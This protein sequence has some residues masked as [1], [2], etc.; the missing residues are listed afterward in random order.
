MAR[1]LRGAQWPPG[2][3]AF[4]YAGGAPTAT[5]SDLTVRR[6]IP[7]GSSWGPYVRT[8]APRYVPPRDPPTG[9][10]SSVLRSGLRVFDEPTGLRPVGESLRTYAPS[11]LAPPRMCPSDTCSSVLARRV[12]RTRRT[13]GG[14]TGQRPVGVYRRRPVAYELPS[15][16]P[17]GPQ[18]RALWAFHC[19]RRRPC[20]TITP[21]RACPQGKALWAFKTNFITKSKIS[22]EIC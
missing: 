7:T 13:T 5:W 20:C 10:P 6:R 14:P 4:H 2:H 19:R 16:P 18:G 15:Y 17:G 11:S 1:T 21:W 9:D 8:Y 12:L 3:W 22:S